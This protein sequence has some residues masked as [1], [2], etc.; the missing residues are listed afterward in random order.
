MVYKLI[1]ATGS[2]GSVTIGGTLHGGSFGA[3]GIFS[4]GIIGALNIGALLGDSALFPVVIAAQ[5]F[6]DPTALTAL[7]IGSLTVAGSVE[8]ADIRAGFSPLGTATS[9][10]V[11]I[12]K[13]KVKG[14]WIASALA[15]GID[16]GSD[17]YYGDATDTII[18][19]GNAIA[20]SIAKIV[21]RGRLLGTPDAVSTTDHFAFTASKIGAFTLGTT[22]ITLNANANDDLPVGTSGDVRIREV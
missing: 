21:I 19:G 12:G 18:A 17:G 7:A 13:V 3:T 1:V 2:I 10:S 11:A 15:A 20:S 8:N 16:T 6:T 5:G 9:H 22:P 4:G 14:D